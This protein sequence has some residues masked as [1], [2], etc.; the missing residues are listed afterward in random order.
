[1][2]LQSFS[3]SDVLVDLISNRSHLKSKVI[4]VLDHDIIKYHLLKIHFDESIDYLI[5]EDIIFEIL[6]FIEIDVVSLG[7]YHGNIIGMP[8]TLSTNG[9]KQELKLSGRLYEAFN[10]YAIITK[11]N[12]F[13]GFFKKSK[14]T[15]NHFLNYCFGSNISKLD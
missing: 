10:Y 13:F 5:D 2:N 15:T 4:K 7:Q 8:I 6:D 11:E 9:V 3:D 12:D 14:S 1:M